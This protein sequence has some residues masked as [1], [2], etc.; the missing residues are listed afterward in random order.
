MKLRY[1]LL[2]RVI[3]EWG[4]SNDTNHSAVLEDV[5]RDSCSR[6]HEYMPFFD[7]DAIGLLAP[8][9]DELVDHEGLARSTWQL[10]TY[11]TIF[12]SYFAV[13]MHHHC[14]NNLVDKC[15]Y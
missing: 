3:K 9:L 13:F 14:L 7:I 12:S 11:E 4:S 5:V 1:I 2:S 10:R 8:V 6:G 15:K